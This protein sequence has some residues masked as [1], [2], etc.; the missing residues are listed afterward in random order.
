MRRWVR[1][2]NRI[3]RQML[4]AAPA[5]ASEARL[6]ERSICSHV[7][8]MGL[9]E[10]QSIACASNSIMP[11]VLSLTLRLRPAMMEP[12]S[13]KMAMW[14]HGGSP[15]RRGTMLSATLIDQRAPHASASWALL[16]S[17]RGISHSRMAVAGWVGDKTKRATPDPATGRSESGC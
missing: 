12:V 5:K 14:S 4:E 8:G 15:L 9:C 2:Y 1:L 3:S 7:M 6:N 17:S 10:S 16:A 13:P 11:G